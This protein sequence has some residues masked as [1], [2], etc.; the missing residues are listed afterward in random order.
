MRIGI[1][2]FDLVLGEGRGGGGETYVTRLVEQLARID[3]VNRYILFVDSSAVAVFGNLNPNFEQFVVPLDSRK[4]WTRAVW[5]QLLLPRAARR[6]KLDVLHSPFNTGPIFCPCRLVVTV[7]DLVNFF[8]RENFPGSDTFKMKYQRYVLRQV[9]RRCARVIAVSHFTRQQIEQRL[10]VDARKMVVIYEAAVGESP[11][12]DENKVVREDF[13]LTVTSDSLHK[14][15]PMLIRGF[16]RI[17]SRAVRLVILG[18]IRETSTPQRMGR[19]DLIRIAE[20]QG[21]ANAVEMR[22]YVTAEELEQLYRRARCLVVPSLYEGFGLPVLEAMRQGL[23]VLC[24]RA[25]SLPEIG[26]NCAWYFD[27]QDEADIAA[28]ISQALAEPGLLTQLASKGLDHARQFSWE[29]VARETLA[30]YEQA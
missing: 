28:K 27:P 14:N 26:G 5:E 25:G 1:N 6:L 15:L 4:K 13:L 19:R 2:L 8:Y 23:P 16:A 3:H 9:V 29:K 10:P 21:V 20:E 22:G 30:V 17:E 18:M 24:A 12:A 7:H 11:P